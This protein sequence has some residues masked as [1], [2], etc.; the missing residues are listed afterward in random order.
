MTAD[1]AAVDVKVVAGGSCTVRPSCC[2]GADASVTDAQCDAQCTTGMDPLEHT[3]A[4]LGPGLWA[5]IIK[6]CAESNP[7]DKAFCKFAGKCPAP[8][9]ARP[10]PP[11]AGPLTQTAG[12]HSFDANVWSRTGDQR[13]LFQSPGSPGQRL[14]LSDEARTAGLFVY[15]NLM[16]DGT[17]A[18]VAVF[19]TASPRTSQSV[20]H[21]IAQGTG[22]VGF[23]GVNF[24][25][26]TEPGVAGWAQ[27]TADPGAQSIPV[28]DS[29]GKVVMRVMPTL[30]Q[31]VGSSY[32]Y[33]GTEAAAVASA[34]CYNENH[35]G[36]RAEGG[37]VRFATP[38]PHLQPRR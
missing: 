18:S 5:E 32:A 31:P 35:R 27:S 24:T 33:R 25:N 26:V 15:T 12:Q 21:P 6:Q 37:P 34:A 13:P 9:T 10:R 19:Q 8:S 11:P 1:G 16:V 38:R 20:F 2:P 14:C 36:A 29:T 28:V 7:N 22:S 30:E 23:G 4:T 17:E 3:T